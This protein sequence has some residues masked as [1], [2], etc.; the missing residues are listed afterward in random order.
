MQDRD[1]FELLT[2]YV[3]EG[4]ES[5]FAALSERHVHLVHSAAW[6]QVN[7]AHVAEEITQAVFILLAKK[8]HTFRKGVIL[9]AWLLR[10]TRFTATNVLVSQY[11]RTRREQEAVQ[12][13]TTDADEHQWEEIAPL[14][15]EAMAG[16]GEQDRNA[17][18]LRFF[19]Q[20]PLAEVGTALG[21]DADAARKRVM[22]AVEKL[23]VFFTKRGVVLSVAGVTAALTANAVQAAPAGVIASV[24]AVATVKGAAVSVSTTTLSKG[25]LKLMAWT[26]LKTTLVLGACALVAGGAI[27]VIIVEAT[28]RPGPAAAR[29]SG[30]NNA[31]DA[32]GRHRGTLVG[33]VTFAA[34][35]VGQAFSLNGTSQYVVVPDAPE[36]NPTG[37]LTVEAW[38]NPEAQFGA[39][40][41][42][43]IKKAGV[44]SAPTEEAQTTGYA[45]ELRGAGAVILGV[46]LAGTPGHWA[47]SPAATVPQNQWT[48]V[49]GVYDGENVSIY[50]NGEPAGSQPAPGR[51]APSHNDLQIGHDP[52]NPD[53]YFKGLIDEA[54]VYDRALSAA[55]I[56][57]SYEAGNSGRALAGR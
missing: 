24:A 29:W 27:T 35:K 19:E 14:L 51:I 16:L 56:H 10:A 34:G 8:A 43:I 52:S 17:L 20:K 4:S 47:F 36:L 53:R 5:A 26:K 48:H 49:A 33:G 3:R 57:T 37:G 23:R 30:E 39:V 18:A 25:V 32:R 15:D 50:L 40:A 2:A 11:R 21:I 9:S 7:D 1:D 55:E 6:R 31:N 13:Q 42:P 12:M 41:P 38:I 46:Y 22:R 44:G 45:L 28:S 54:A